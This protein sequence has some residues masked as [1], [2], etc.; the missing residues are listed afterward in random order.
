MTG[1]SGV[2]DASVNGVTLAYETFGDSAAP[3]V[4][5]VM[6]LGTQM[7][8][9]HD[10]FCE[11]LA[12]QGHHVIRFDN[13]DIGLSTHLDDL[14][15]GKPVGAFLG[16][17]PSY[18]VPDMADDAAALLAEL[19][20]EGAHVVGVS[21]GGCISQSLTLRHPSLVRSLTSISSSTGSRRVGRPRL[22]IA[23]T[24]ITR[25]AASSREEAIALSVATWRRIGSPGYPFDLARVERLAGEAYD[26]R[27]DPAGVSRQFA[28]ILGSPDRTAALATVEVPTLVL[29]GE[30]DPLITVSGGIATAD[31]IPGAELITFPGMGHD[32]P[33][34]LWPRFV[35]AITGVTAKGE[36]VRR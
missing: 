35:E 22:D 24:M 6:G 3:P 18:L 31:A 15:P 12:D 1:P 32:L 26:R 19:T 9:W 36:Q 25:R 23:R 29:H 16:R 33:E 14:P 21:M 10:V 30:A 13:R 5:L 20:P 27:Y 2:R 4:L 28:A 34:P 8:A 11:M 17:R 7:I